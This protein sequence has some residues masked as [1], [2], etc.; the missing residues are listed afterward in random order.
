MTRPLRAAM[1][2]C[3]GVCNLAIE[4]ARLTRDFEIAA[5]QDPDPAALARVGERLPE[6]RRHTVFE[7][8][9]AADIDFVIVNSPNH[10]HLP[11]VRAA[12][13][14]GKPCLVQKPIAP[15]LAEAAEM[16][17][18]AAAHGVKLGVTMFELSRPIHHQVKAMIASGWLGRPVLVSA[19]GA[20]TGYL[21]TPPAPGDWR[22]DPAKV[23]G[24]AFIQL[25]VHHVNLAAWLLDREAVRASAAGARGLTVFED[26]TMLATVEF[27]DGVMA[28]F[29]TSYAADLYAFAVIGDRGRIHLLPEHVVVRGPEPFRGEVFDYT[30]AGR[31][32]AIPAAALAER[33]RPLEAALE[34]H[35]RFARWI[36]RSEPYPCPGERA[37]HDMRVVEAVYRACRTGE[38]A[39]IEG[40]P[41]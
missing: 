12:A 38:A 33:S 9:L 36:A 7:D 8:L 10:L 1:A 18:I 6:A 3:G 13:A 4:G 2:A 5:I 26:E 37:L 34:V 41:R 14:A 15:T 24:G 16:V 30:E 32:V 28:R 11:Q 25:G 21:A 29:A 31:E 22:R 23:G 40:E 35:G 39:G 27:A 19:V 20:H 17:R